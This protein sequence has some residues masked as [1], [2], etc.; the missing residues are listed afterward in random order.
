MKT[1]AIMGVGASK[2]MSNVNWS[3]QGLDPC[4][5]SYL[6]RM[7]PDCISYDKAVP[8]DLLIPFEV[9]EV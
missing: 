2:R 6:P 4:L 8:D 1:T 7:R 5:G 9:D 3:G